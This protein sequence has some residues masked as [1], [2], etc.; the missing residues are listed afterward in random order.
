MVIVIAWYIAISLAGALICQPVKSSWDPKVVGHC[1]NRYVLNIIAPLP[2]ILTDFAILLTP[3]PMVWKL[4]INTRHKVALAG[5][6]LVGGLWV[7]YHRPCPS[8]PLTYNRTCIVS[9]VRYRYTFFSIEDPTCGSVPHPAYGL[10]AYMSTGDTTS[11]GNWNLIEANTTIFCA[12]L[13]GSKPVAMFLFPDK[14]L[15]KARSYY[16]R[17]FRSNHSGQT[18]QPQLLPSKDSFEDFARLPDI[19]SYE[20]QRQAHPSKRS[21]IETNHNLAGH[22][23][24]DRFNSLK[25]PQ[26]ALNRYNARA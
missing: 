1:G 10:P 4:H 15:S 26:P 20:L 2:W 9:C 22:K 7:T 25:V 11:L 13:F 23:P 5:L 14:L 3:L 17:S 24:L 19:P 18:P 6:F 16:H 12:C 21:D 8:L